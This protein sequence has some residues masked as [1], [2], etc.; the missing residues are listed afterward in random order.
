MRIGIDVDGVLAYDIAY[1]WGLKI[2]RNFR[3]NYKNYYYYESFDEAI[4][5]NK[6]LL[7]KNP[8]DFWKNK[9]LYD[10]YE[11]SSDIKRFLR[12][13]NDAY[14]NAEFFIISDC[15][16]EHIASKEAFLKR[17]WNLEKPFKFINTKDKHLVECNLYID[18]RP[19]ILK[20][21][22]EFL[23]DTKTILIKHFYN[24]PRLY[25]KFEYIDRIL[26]VRKF[27]KKF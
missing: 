6:N 1:D 20:N 10:S 25:D 15:F 14:P 4:K 7:V 22:K 18:D 11:F 24:N 21:C 23:P 3:E 2:F 8:Y 27:L 12:C 9:N 5:E 16:E 19:Q 13:L 26:D 17:E